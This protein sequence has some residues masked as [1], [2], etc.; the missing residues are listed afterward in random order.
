MMQKE[1][2]RRGNAADALWC[3][4]V[5]A[6]ATKNRNSDRASPLPER[7]WFCLRRRTFMDDANPNQSPDSPS[8]EAALDTLREALARER[9]RSNRAELR[10]DAADNERRAAEAR[11]DRAE[12]R[13]ARAEADAHS[14]RTRADALRH[15]VDVAEHGQREA[16]EAAGV[17]RHQAQE[18]HR[19]AEE[20]KAALL[21]G[22]R[23]GGRLRRLWRAWR[24]E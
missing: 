17:S 7:Y 16:E 23:A 15:R 24:G 6:V 4:M 21:A 8:A 10:A 5:R 18:A 3:N 22:A 13:A 19:A 20:A 12:E 9:D 1:Y 14:E 2:K 11:S